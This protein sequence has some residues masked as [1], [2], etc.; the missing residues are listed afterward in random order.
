PSDWHDS[1]GRSRS[2]QPVATKTSV[3]VKHNSLLEGR[4][5]GEALDIL[6]AVLPKGG[7]EPFPAGTVVK[8]PECNQGF[9]RIYTGFK[10]ETFLR[11]PE[12]F[13]EI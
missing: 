7:R 5:M 10:V 8:H 4:V 9:A 1:G 11:V 3:S 12:V 2:V 13:E 6:F